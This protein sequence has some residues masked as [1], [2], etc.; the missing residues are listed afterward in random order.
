MRELIVVLIIIIAVIAM[1]WYLRSPRAQ[2]A[3]KPKSDEVRGIQGNVGTSNRAG[4]AA[5]AT[6]PATAPSR[7]TDTVAGMTDEQATAHLAE[8]TATLTQARHD[9]ER[10]AARLSN[11]GETALAIQT[12][13]AAYGGVLPG[14]GTRECPP[15]YPIK[16]NATSMLFHQSDSPT[17]M[18][19]IAEYCFSSV[20]AAEAAGF[21]SPGREK[22]AASTRVQQD[23][24]R[25]A[26]RFSNESEAR[27]DAERVAA[28]FSNESEKAL[29]IQTAA[30]AYGG[31]L[32][33]D[34]TRECPS[35]Y[36]IKGNATS[37]LYHEPGTATYLATIAEYC[38]A[39]A[40]GARAAGFS[41][42]AY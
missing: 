3:A 40:E 27:L 22:P 19:T 13:A 39:S 16:G 33:A 34:G 24:E 6:R 5:A 26:A 32:P 11:R 37:L 28:R 15:S 36:P 10:V 38:F 4:S 2:T 17:Y 41:S 1:I 23:A 8:P 20:E 9:A 35:A 30:A 14:D 42:T 31:V 12:A 18:A 25:V 7:T 29:A 21:S